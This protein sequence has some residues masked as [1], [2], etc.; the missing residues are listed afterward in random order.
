[1]LTCIFCSFAQTALEP[2]VRE[3]WHISHGRGWLST[4][5]LVKK[6]KRSGGAIF[7][8]LV[9]GKMSVIKK[10]HVQEQGLMAG[11]NCQAGWGKTVQH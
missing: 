9:L 2:A 5:L 8:G 7:P 3:K 1:M 11:S 4:G 6:E 10:A